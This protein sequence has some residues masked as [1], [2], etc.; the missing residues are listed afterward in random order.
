L[1][2]KA[3]KGLKLHILA[4]RGDWYNVLLPDGSQGWVRNDLVEI[5][6]VKP[7]SPREESRRN[8][9]V[10]TQLIAAGQ[11]STAGAVLKANP[12]A[13]TPPA[14]SAAEVSSW[15]PE[16][17]EALLVSFVVGTSMFIVLS[18][19]GTLI[20]FQ[21]NLNQIRT[22][23]P[24]A[25]SDNSDL[26]LDESTASEM[27]DLIKT[28]DNDLNDLDEAI[29]GCLQ[30]LRQPNEHQEESSENGG[31]DMA[32]LAT[33]IHRQQQQITHYLEL[34]S[35][36]HKKLNAYQRENL[37][38]RRMMT[39]LSVAPVQNHITFPYRPR[40]H[41]AGLSIKPA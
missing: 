2:T 23:L 3:V 19:A 12:P 22:K 1:V 17:P 13:P 26:G 10:G 15:L 36:Q 6:R 40:R 14:A 39:G 5:E 4:Q 38:V 34:L 20:V 28:T 8:R 27:S 16:K 18:L 30:A 35:L 31:G 29:E 33:T 32:Y 24:E 25:I 41:S 21:R 37:R 9:E 7:P 11:P